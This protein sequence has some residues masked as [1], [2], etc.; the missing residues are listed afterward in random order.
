VY[1][2]KTGLFAE[3]VLHDT[4]TNNVSIINLFEHLSFRSFPGSVPKISI[5]FLIERQ[6]GD[7]PLPTISFTL[8]LS[9]QVV[10]TNDGARIDFG[11]KN[12]TRL[13]VGIGGLVISEAGLECPH[14]SGRRL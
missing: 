5:Y 6:D 8:S 3:S 2:L 13:V 1:S 14:S 9:G 12:Q 10:L 7:D 11:M 4:Q